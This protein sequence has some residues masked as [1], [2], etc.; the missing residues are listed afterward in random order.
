MTPSG[1]VAVDLGSKNGTFLGEARLAGPQALR[2]GDR[3]RLGG[4]ELVYEDPAEAM[5]RELEAEAIPDGPKAEPEAQG[6]VGA[7]GQNE[8][9]GPEPLGKEPRAGAEEASVAEP[10]GARLPWGAGT[11]LLVALG[12]TVVAGALWALGRLFL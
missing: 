10:P 8:P 1:A 2:S 5:L 12:L 4:T 3:L 6:S 11:L 7:S 9:S